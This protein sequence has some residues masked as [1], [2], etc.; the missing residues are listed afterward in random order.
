MFCQYSLILHRG[1]GKAN[2]PWLYT[3]NGIL[4]ISH[5]FICRSGFRTHS[6]ILHRWME[7]SKHFLDSAER[8]KSTSGNIPRWHT[9]EEDLEAVHD[10]IHRRMFGKCLGILWAVVGLANLVLQKKAGGWAVLIM[11]TVG[12]SPESLNMSSAHDVWDL[13]RVQHTK[14]KLLKKSNQCLIK[15]STKYN[16]RSTGYLPLNLW[17]YNCHID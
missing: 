8:T 1:R 13:Y 9:P 2:R 12:Q 14:R 3:Q 16:V 6:K 17:D 11:D 7:S 4:Q 10:L 15:M 5:D